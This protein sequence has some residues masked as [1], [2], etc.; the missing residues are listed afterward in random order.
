M[1][2][3]TG[4][5]SIGETTSDR[6]QLILVTGFAIAVTLLALVLLLNTA[7]YT[8][9]VATRTTTDDTTEAI[10]FRGST[11]EAIAGYIDAENDT[12]AVGA[13]ID[14]M[15]EVTRNRST[16]RGQQSSVQLLDQ[17]NGTR[18]TT[19]T[20]GN[21]TANETDGTAWTVVSDADMTR[22]F[23]LHLSDVHGTDPQSGLQV[24]INGSD[25]QYLYV[26]ETGGDVTVANSTDPD[27]A[28]ATVA[29]TAPLNSSLTFDVTGGTLGN[30][31]C[32]SIF[33][34]VGTHSIEIETG[35]AAEGTFE[36]V[37]TGTPDPSA[38]RIVTDEAVYDV[39]VRLRYV[40]DT[41]TVETTTRIAPGEP[42]A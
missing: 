40:T 20:V 39:T 5:S 41:V 33:P 11:V 17:T 29:C 8:E 42:H 15:A 2:D 12:A 36:L 26:Y 25:E 10:E 21:Y 24:A 30:A 9:N 1:A 37:T 16:R 18:V 19:E 22:A 4:G 23:Q 31:S 28:T 14:R 32:G 27:P 3:V 35:D 34:D 38:D 7:I 13:R 6:G